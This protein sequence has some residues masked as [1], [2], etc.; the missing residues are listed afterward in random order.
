MLHSYLE[1]S[2]KNKQ[3]DPDSIIKAIQAKFISKLHRTKF[4]SKPIEN[5]LILIIR[6][7]ENSQNFVDFDTFKDLYD[8]LALFVNYVRIIAKYHMLYLRE[9]S[10][11]ILYTTEI[12][13][14]NQ[15][16]QNL[17]RIYP[18]S[19]EKLL[20]IISV[21][22]NV[23]SAENYTRLIENI[24]VNLLQLSISTREISLCFTRK[25]EL[26]E[27]AKI[28]PESADNQCIMTSLAG[29]INTSE[30]LMS[31]FTDY[32]PV[33]T[34][35]GSVALKSQCQ[36]VTNKDT[37]VMREKARNY[38]DTLNGEFC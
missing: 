25:F 22:N 37:S 36:L 23:F 30:K 18:I 28:S 3:H 24:Q 4:Y 11:N 13:K 14:C 38:M 34:S 10:Q 1:S 9:E 31:S 5:C 15:Q 12:R 17:T 6:A 26:E 33:L 7:I 21:I 27:L 32:L 16:L 19:L 2:V 29:L 8:N 35:Y 20:N